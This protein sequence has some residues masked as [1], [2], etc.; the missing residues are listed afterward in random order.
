M[1]VFVYLDCIL[2]S[3]ISIRISRNRSKN[4]SDNHL[5]LRGLTAKL[6][7]KKI[8]VIIY[9]IQALHAYFIL[10]KRIYRLKV[11]NFSIIVFSAGHSLTAAT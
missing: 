8:T 5:C 11:I 2:D 9:M 3:L 6:K 1:H 10:T 4:G 7:Y